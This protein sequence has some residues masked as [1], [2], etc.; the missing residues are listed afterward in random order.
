MNG[1]SVAPHTQHLATAPQPQWW[2]WCVTVC[3]HYPC[4]TSPAPR[5]PPFLSTDT[6]KRARNIVC[7]RYK[8]KD[9]NAD[10]TTQTTQTTNATTTF[11]SITVLRFS[12]LA[13]IHI[14]THE[15]T[16]TLIYT[17]TSSHWHSRNDDDEPHVIYHAIY[18]I[19]PRHSHYITRSVFFHP[20]FSY[21]LAR[22]R[23]TPR[24]DHSRSVITS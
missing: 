9:D 14:P 11:R 3:S 15:H 5:S 13:Y 4:S 17:E 20:P 12:T 24:H 7:A 22:C 1:L 21:T 19:V 10:T 8:K 2:S 16:H 6:A 18:I 23:A